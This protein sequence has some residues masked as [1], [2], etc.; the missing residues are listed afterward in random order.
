[1]EGNLWLNIGLK[2]AEDI[3]ELIAEFNSIIKRGTGAQ[4]QKTN[5]KLNSWSIHGNSLIKL[6]ERE[7]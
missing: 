4:D 3:E 6:K 5:L 1:M 7:N 2:T